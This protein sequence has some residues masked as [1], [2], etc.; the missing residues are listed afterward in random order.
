MEN[1]FSTD[2]KIKVELF[3][4]FLFLCK[5]K[6][7]SIRRY[8]EN[9]TL[10][11]FLEINKNTTDMEEINSLLFYYF[12]MFREDHFIL[13]L[14]NDP[15]F[16]N[17]LLIK[18][19]Y[20]GYGQWIRQGNNPDTFLLN[21][22]HF[23]TQE[24]CLDLL[25]NSF[26]IVFNDHTFTL[27]LITTLDHA[28]IDKFF[29]STPNI[30]DITEFF[31]DLFENLE[32]EVIK[33]FFFKNYGLYSYVIQLFNSLDPSSRK[34]KK[35]FTQYKKHL[36]FIHTIEKIVELISKECD[37]ET[38]RKLPK[39]KRN[40]NRLKILLQELNTILDKQEAIYILNERN[41]FIDEAEK[42]LVLGIINNDFLKNSILKPH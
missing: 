32:E 36:D 12:W 3:D 15:K 9:L 30:K 39:E 16:P 2:V 24:K 34:Y 27:F 19:I 41:T 42:H 10:N 11:Q 28:S 33:H 14:I 38:E 23:L 29:T 20:Y 40:T 25:H 21:S 1:S 13:N 6:V 5:G 8:F 35:F 31:S 4:L 26:D 22:A 7:N 37:I 18:F 17:E